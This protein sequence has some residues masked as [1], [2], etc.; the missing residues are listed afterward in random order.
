M[1]TLN[2]I[3]LQNIRHDCGACASTCTKLEY[4]KTVTNDQ[5]AV[6]IMDKICNACK[7]LKQDLISML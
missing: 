1:D 6:E 7:N 5:N 2:Q 4:Y 3:E